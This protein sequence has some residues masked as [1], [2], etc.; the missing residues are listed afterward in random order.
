VRPFLVG[1]KSRSVKRMLK[2]KEGDLFP[3]EMV[4]KAIDALKKEKRSLKSAWRDD[5]DAFGKSGSGIHAQDDHTL[6]INTEGDVPFLP[7]L[8]ARSAFVPLHKSVEAHRAKAFESGSLVSNGPFHLAGRG[9]K[10]PEHQQQK[11]VLSVVDLARN[12]HYNGSNPAKVDGVK[13]F[14]DQGIQEDV[15]GFEQGALRWVNTTWLEFPAKKLRAKVEALKGYGVRASPVVLYLRFRCDR[16]PFKDKNARKAFALS[17]SRDKLTKWFWP[18]GTPAFRLVP[19]G[20]EGRTDGISCPKPNTGAARDAYAATGGIEWVELSFGETPGQDDA[21][22]QLIKGWK[23]TLGIESSKRIETENDIRNILRS[24]KYYAM[25]TTYRGF[26]NDPYAYLA[27]LHSAD[28]DSGLGWRDTAYDTLLDAARDP[29]TALDDPEGFLS[30]TG[31]PQLKSALD[32]AKGGKDGRLR[33]RREVLAAA[34]RRLLDEYV[35]VPLL[36]LKEATMI[37]AVNGLGSEEA[38]RNPGY[39][40]SLWNVSK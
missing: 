13:C 6:V 15:I 39:V 31:M 25:L 23:K 37:G 33:L 19:P 24:G 21:G 29:Q 27:P 9:A 35:V 12:P 8:L 3:P 38:R 40:G 11:K 7:E 10:P 16:T 22:D 28:A 4:T 5:F 34:E 36:F 14:T 32:A 18:G 30:K 2:W 17:L 1:V 26:V 20:I